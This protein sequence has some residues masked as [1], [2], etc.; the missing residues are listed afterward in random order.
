MY[1]FLMV[2]S[3]WHSSRLTADAVCSLIYFPAKR[4]TYVMS[5]LADVQVMSV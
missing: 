1:M 5:C 4:L 3:M 2:N